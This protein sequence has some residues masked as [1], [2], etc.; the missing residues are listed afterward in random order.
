MQTG[1]TGRARSLT[2]TASM[3]YKAQPC[4]FV[5]VLFCRIF[6]PVM[7]CS[8]KSPAPSVVDRVLLTANE[9]DQFLVKVMVRQCRRPEVGDKFASRHGQKGVCGAIVSQEDM[10]FSDT[11]VCPDVIMN[12][13]GFPSRMTV[14]KIIE[15]V[16]NPALACIRHAR[17][18][19]ES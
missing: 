18:Q 9:T 4:T 1:R 11:G 13:H 3:S 8:Y 7:I 6:N 5:L 16:Y 14:G 19:L 15:L 2:K 12:P 17:I 10:P